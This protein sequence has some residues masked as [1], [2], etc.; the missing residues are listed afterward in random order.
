LAEEKAKRDAAA[1]DKNER[2][3]FTPQQVNGPVRQ[4]IVDLYHAGV[5]DKDFTTLDEGLI[6][7]IIDTQ[8]TLISTGLSTRS[9]SLKDALAALGYVNSEKADERMDITTETKKGGWTS[10]DVT[11][12]KKVEAK[13]SPELFADDELSRL[14]A[15]G[16][17]TPEAVGEMPIYEIPL[18]QARD[19]LPMIRDQ[20]AVGDRF[21]IQNRLYQKFQNKDGS[22]ELRAI[23]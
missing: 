16:Q 9:A 13:K 8:Q 5:K 12:V 22:T 4:A 17:I 15:S 19:V 23:N 11:S 2:Y 1:G 7:K 21:K 14:I 3:A 10:D 20:A 18:E 6:R